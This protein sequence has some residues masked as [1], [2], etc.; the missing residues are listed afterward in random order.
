M[1]C[2]ET[3]FTCKGW[4][5]H[6]NR[7][8]ERHSRLLVIKGHS[9]YGK[10]GW[11][12]VMFIYIT[13]SLGCFSSHTQY[14]M[15]ESCSKH[16]LN[17]LMWKA[18]VSSFLHWQTDSGLKGVSNPFFPSVNGAEDEVDILWAGM[19]EWVVRYTV[20]HSGL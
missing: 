10:Y 20:M 3:G 7:Q 19:M 9:W 5:W 18:T 13:S 6:V 14:E 15:L 4:I 11:Y 8:N 12:V 17:T 16:I 2:G 1:I